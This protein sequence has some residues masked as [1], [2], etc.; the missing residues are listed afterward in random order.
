[1]GD[2]ANALG[3]IDPVSGLVNNI[4]GIGKKP[5]APAITPPAVMPTPDDKSIMDAKRRQAAAMQQR[6]GRQS[7]I[8][9]TDQT[10]G[11]G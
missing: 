11:G 6:S 9:S 4:L 2:F 1:M 3:K 5:S 7:T 8:L 10:L